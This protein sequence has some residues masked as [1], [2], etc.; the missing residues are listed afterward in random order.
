MH[1]IAVPHQV[2]AP[3]L[4]HAPGAAGGLLPAERDQLVRR[5]GLGADEAAREIGVD[6][7]GG[8]D[9]RAARRN[10]P[11]A[12]LGLGGREEADQ[13]EEA[14]PGVDHAIQARRLEPER[15]E[16]LARLRR[17]FE[18]GDLGFERGRDHDLLRAGGG[19]MGGNGW[20]IALPVAALASSTLLT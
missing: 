12:R 4:P 6:A 16:E 19:G 20:L 9:R 14:V 15:Y 10:R 3:L 2:G 13:A 18:Q 5:D 11:G 7:A 17:V 1:H 8:L